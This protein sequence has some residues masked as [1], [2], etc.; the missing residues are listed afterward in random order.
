MVDRLAGGSQ[1]SQ[2]K[3]YQRQSLGGFDRFL[4][5]AGSYGCRIRVFVE[6][7]GSTVRAF[8]ITQPG[9]ADLQFDGVLPIAALAGN[10]EALAIALG[11]LRQLVL[12][13]L[14]LGEVQERSGDVFARA[15]LAGQR[16]RLL[17]QFH[18]FRHVS[19]LLLNRG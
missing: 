15:D 10:V 13:A 14:Q 11:R 19:L 5:C 16:Q 2:L 3:E 12:R 17:T 1:I 7:P 6:L 8:R 18:G 9:K 4:L